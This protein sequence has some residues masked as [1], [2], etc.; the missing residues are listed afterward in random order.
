MQ[1]YFQVSLVLKIQMTDGY[2]AFLISS[3][4]WTTAPLHASILPKH[5]LNT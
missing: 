3:Y 1:Y 5:L 4:V 2:K